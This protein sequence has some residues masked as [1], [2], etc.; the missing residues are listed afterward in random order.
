MR[1]ANDEEA[2]ASGFVLHVAYTFNASLNENSGLANIR[3]LLL[4]GFKTERANQN[5]GNETKWVTVAHRNS[6]FFQRTRHDK[7]EE[8]Q[9]K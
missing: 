1:K 7:G 4:L 3:A 6:L 8:W 5:E 9:S 2:N